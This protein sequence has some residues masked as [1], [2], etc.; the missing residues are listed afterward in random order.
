[1]MEEEKGGTGRRGRDDEGREGRSVV[2]T[3]S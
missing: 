1:M 2:S 3:T